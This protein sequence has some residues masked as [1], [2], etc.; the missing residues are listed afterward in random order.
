MI[1][2]VESMPKLSIL[3]QS[4]SYSKCNINP[5]FRH[6]VFQTLLYFLTILDM[7]IDVFVLFKIKDI[8]FFRIN[9]YRDV[10]VR[11]RH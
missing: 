7:N 8:S 2:Y 5:F 6:S 11:L 3:V 9:W 10:T 1:S 4:W